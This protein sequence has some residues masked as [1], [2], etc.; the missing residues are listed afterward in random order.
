MTRWEGRGI[1]RYKCILLLDRINILDSEGTFRSHNVPNL[2]EISH[3]VSDIMCVCVCVCVCVQRIERIK[4]RER[5]RE[6]ERE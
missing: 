5:E 6:R 2:V 4:E 1:E 3:I